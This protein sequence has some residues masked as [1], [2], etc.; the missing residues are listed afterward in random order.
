M[1]DWI[2]E[3]KPT[4]DDAEAAVLAVAAGDWDERATARWLR[5]QLQPLA[6]EAG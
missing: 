4:V 6:T 3:P 1:N 5:R 2:W